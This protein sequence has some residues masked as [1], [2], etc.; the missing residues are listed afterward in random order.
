MV[1]AKVK[2][3][4][5]TNWR[6]AHQAAEEGAQFLGFN[7]YARSPRYI[8]PAKAR[9]IVR[10]LPRGISAVGVFVNETARRMAEI[11]RVAGLS[12]VQLHGEETSATLARLKRSLPAVKIIKAVRVG[13][14]FR[15]AQLARFKQADAI[16]LDGFDSKR[17]GGTGKTFDWSL[18]RRAKRATDHG[19][20]LL[21]GGLTP[22]NIAEAIR[23]ARPFAVDVC[24][25]V[26]AK[27]GK[28]DPAR[29]KAL[30]RAANGTRSG[31]TRPKNIKEAAR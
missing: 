19:R 7:F 29:L 14:S 8:A 28:K 31:G 30:L 17:R 16:L 5:I 6:D 25:G 11:A 18:A 3:C 24:S 21:A 10:R 27:P 13:K 4:G 20:I 2:I 26:E 9:R 23:I 1:K 12:W 15:P 22:D